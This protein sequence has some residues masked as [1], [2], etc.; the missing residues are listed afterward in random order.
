MKAREKRQRR[1]TRKANRSR[2]HLKASAFQEWPELRRQREALLEAFYAGVAE[3]FGVSRNAFRMVLADA[4]PAVE[5][6]PAVRARIEKL[7][8]QIAEAQDG[9]VKAASRW[10]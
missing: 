5:L 2:Y 9:T 8:E 4:V 1:A 10:T 3:K 6:P 7:N